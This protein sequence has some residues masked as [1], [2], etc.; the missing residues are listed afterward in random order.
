MVFFKEGGNIGKGGLSTVYRSTA[1]SISPLDIEKNIKIAKEYLASGIGPG[2]IPL[3]EDDKKALRER[4]SL[5]ESQIT[6]GVK[7]ITGL[8]DIGGKKSSLVDPELAADIQQ[9]SLSILQKDLYD[10]EQRKKDLEQ[11]KGFAL[12]QA[13]LGILA[14]DPSRGALA[15]VGEGAQPAL[16]TLAGIQ[17]EIRDLPAT[18]QAAELAKLTSIS[19]L[20]ENLG[21]IDFSN[22]YPL[23]VG[24][25]TTISDFEKLAIQLKG[26]PLISTDKPV[27][28]SI[29]NEARALAQR[30][31]RSSPTLSQENTSYMNLEQEI[32]KR[33]INNVLISK[34]DSKVKEFD[35]NYGQQK[36]TFA[37]LSEFIESTK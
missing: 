24:S 31:A 20:L 15:A 10:A 35:S 29:V 16:Q 23:D 7:D 5:Q 37:N 3:T 33:Y 18:Q 12:A 13:G 9:R 34:E 27:V 6:E 21:D 26:G 2:N 11:D 1:G 4:I 30:I 19:D 8:T 32:F 25:G 17:K 36:P 22:V 14:A 28:N